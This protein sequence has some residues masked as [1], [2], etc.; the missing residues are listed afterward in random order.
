M[1]KNYLLT[2]SLEPEDQHKLMELRMLE[3][4]PPP[5]LRPGQLARMTE[6]QQWLGTAGTK[7]LAKLASDLHG[8]VAVRFIEE[9]LE[10]WEQQVD[11][12]R[13]PP[14]SERMSDVEFQ[15]IE[16]KL[17][18]LSSAAY[19]VYEVLSTT[20]QDFDT[21]LKRYRNL[22]KAVIGNKTEWYSA[23]LLEVP[24][25]SEVFKITKRVA[26]LLRRYQIILQKLDASHKILS[27]RRL[28]TRLLAEPSQGSLTIMLT[29][30]E[31]FRVRCMQQ[32]GIQTTMTTNS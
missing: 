12:F 16:A 20:N 4:V 26:G 3:Q 29:T 11:K 21:M 17:Q 24:I 25:S 18:M 9:D 27:R 5:V 8:M 32:L 7:I 23:A 30:L 10:G 2:L 31:L 6:L 28:Y 22:C 14:A 19:D 13:L 1:Q 15:A